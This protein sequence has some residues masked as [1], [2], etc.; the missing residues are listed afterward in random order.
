[1][2]QKMKNLMKENLREAKH[3]FLNCAYVYLNS[4]QIGFPLQL[5]FFFQRSRN[6]LFSLKTE[7]VLTLLL[8]FF[9]F[10]PLL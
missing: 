8:P 3:V 10:I 6:F 2:I 5:P 4:S 7:A 9:T 1:M